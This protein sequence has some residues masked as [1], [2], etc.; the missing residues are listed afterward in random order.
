MTWLPNWVLFTTVKG[1]KMQKVV[2]SLTDGLDNFIARPDGDTLHRMS[3]W[4]E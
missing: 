2:Y 4:W 3:L 1:A